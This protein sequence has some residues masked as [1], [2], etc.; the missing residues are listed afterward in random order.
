M[1]PQDHLEFFEKRNAAMM[2]FLPFYVTPHPR[3]LRFAHRE[4][5]V[6]F[7]PR[8]SQ[9]LFERAR[10]PTGRVRL[11]FTDKLRERLVLPQFCQDVNVVG[12]SVH[13]QCDSPF[14]ADRAADVFVNPRADR[15]NHPRFA[16]LRRKHDVIQEVAIGGTHAMTPFRRPCPGALLPSHIT[17]GVPLRSTPGFI[18]SHPS[19]ALT[20][21]GSCFSSRRLGHVSSA[22]EARWIKALR[23]TPGFILSHP[24]GALT[25]AGSCSSSRKLGHVSSAPEARWIK[26]LRSTPDFILSHPSGA[27]T[28][29]GSCFSSRS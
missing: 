14:T 5:A 21:A 11:Q 8:E 13:N 15:R 2:L 29:A 3:N 23:S 27:L 17:P 1:R 10:N 4:R 18:L 9:C 26:A 16:V 20:V 12:G 19:G 22:P 6:T 7:L 24:S 28:V 25:V